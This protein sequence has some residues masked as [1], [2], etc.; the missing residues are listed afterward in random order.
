MAKRIPTDSPLLQPFAIS[1]EE[2]ELAQ[3]IEVHKDTTQREEIELPDSSYIQPVQDKS[4]TI[5]DQTRALTTIT[6]NAQYQLAADFRQNVIIPLLVKIDDAYD[7]SIRQ[8]H[9]LHKGLIS[10]KRDLAAPFTQAKTEIDIALSRYIAAERER[11]NRERM[12]QERAAREQADLMRAREAQEALDCGDDAL[13]MEL[14]TESPR[15]AVHIPS[16]FQKPSAQGIGSRTLKRFEILDASKIKR[17]FLIPDET[18]IGKLIT[19]LGA[20]AEE[21]VGRGSIRYYEVD[22]ISQARRS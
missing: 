2:I 3:G 16:T 21:I 15:A 10:K 6:D 1:T 11:Q 5:L 20:R 14:A 19:H 13:L 22:S 12:A 9:E 7:A 4:L 8:A 18:A 17:E